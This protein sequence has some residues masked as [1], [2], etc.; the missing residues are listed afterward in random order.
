MTVDPDLDVRRRE[1]ANWF[2][3][4]NQRRVAASDITGFS[5]WRRTPENAA[6]YL[7][8]ERMW[9]AAET[10]GADPDI[11]LLSRS[12]RNRADAARKARRLTRVLLP[13]GAVACGAMLVVGGMLWW[14]ST[15]SYQTAV[16]ERRTVALEDGSRVTLDTASHVRV[17][18]TR[19]RRSVELI[20]GQA[21]FAVTGNPNR[22]FVVSAGD[23]D[24]T[25]VG[26]RFD[27]RRSGDGA[28]VTLVEGK[29]EVRD[30]RPGASE[31]AL[32]PGQQVA[33]FAPRPAVRTV[34]T[35]VTTSWTSGRLIFSGQSLQ[36]AVAEVNRYST[37]KIV[38]EAPNVASTSVSGAFN[39][40]DVDGFVAALLDLYPVEA[41]RTA[42]GR[43]LISDASAKKVEAP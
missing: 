38:L 17:R 31:W 43:I 23:T 34:N 19:G 16:G 24:V 15:Q 39:A 25:A 20:D 18:F 8:I 2:A 14:P 42:D 32:T 35:S 36:S 33:T 4:L 41:A 37:R 7:K 22:P 30:Q 3:R 27:V 6:A 1:A 26:T 5:Q 40:G 13:I 29:V 21:F 28:L 10:L 9:E 12:A 11:A